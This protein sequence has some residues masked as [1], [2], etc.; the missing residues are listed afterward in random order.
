LYKKILH[1]V[2]LSQK[3]ALLKVKDTKLT[4]KIS[5]TIIFEIVT[6]FIIFKNKNYQNIQFT[7]R[8]Q[9]TSSFNEKCFTS[10]QFLTN[11]NF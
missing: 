4:I 2:I 8:N 6:F 9:P 7:H 3:Q 10:H 5:R 11:F 1:Y